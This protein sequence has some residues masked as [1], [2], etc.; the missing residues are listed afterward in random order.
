MLVDT[1]T[2][3]KL[4]EGKA[5]KTISRDKRKIAEILEKNKIEMDLDGLLIQL[6]DYG[7]RIISSPAPK[8]EPDH[9]NTRTNTGGRRFVCWA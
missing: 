4:K 5:M 1:G 8:G 3:T 2:N 6:D 9:Y 7:D